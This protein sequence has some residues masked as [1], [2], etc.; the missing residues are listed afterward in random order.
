[1]SYFMLVGKG[2]RNALFICL[3]METDGF[4]SENEYRLGTGYLSLN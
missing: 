4:W 2:A 1:M 3:F